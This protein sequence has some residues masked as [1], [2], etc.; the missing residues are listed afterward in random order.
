M[1]IGD[2]KREAWTPTTATATKAQRLNGEQLEVAEAAAE[3]AAVETA[4]K[5]TVAALEGAVMQEE[6]LTQEKKRAKT[7]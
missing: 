2:V 3:A 4:G 5:T 1:I 6:T 7:T